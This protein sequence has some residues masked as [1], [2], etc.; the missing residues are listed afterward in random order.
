MGIQ[1]PVIYNSVKTDSS[2]GSVTINNL[3]ETYTEIYS[4]TGYG[5]FFGA[6]M[7]L[8]ATGITIKLE[9]DG[10]DVFEVTASSLASFLGNLNSKDVKPGGS[11]PLYYD[12]KKHFHIQYP[13]PIQYK[14]SIR[15]LA[16]AN[17]GN[18]TRRIDGYIASLTKEG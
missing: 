5:T 1:T 11:L 8:S 13:A 18:N 4:Y 3:N 2:F 10:F 15:I 16:R 6:V 14:E 7:K 9:V 17:S 12:N